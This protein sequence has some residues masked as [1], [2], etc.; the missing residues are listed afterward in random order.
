MK[1]LAVDF[2]KLDGLYKGGVVFLITVLVPCLLVVLTDVLNN[3]SNL[4]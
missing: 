4:L 1:K 2:K 3:G